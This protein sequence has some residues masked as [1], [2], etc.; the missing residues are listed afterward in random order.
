MNNNQ[1]SN[2]MNGQ[3]HLFTSFPESHQ[4]EVCLK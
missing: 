2:N 3:T 4:D 1:I